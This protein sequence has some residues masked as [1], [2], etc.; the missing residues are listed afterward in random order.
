MDKWEKKTRGR[1]KEKSILGW[2]AFNKLSIYSEV[3]NVS[4]GSEKVKLSIS[5]I[6]LF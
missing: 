1:N 5:A 3:E 6:Y 2:V 4:N